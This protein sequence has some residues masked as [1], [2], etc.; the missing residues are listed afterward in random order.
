MQYTQRKLQRSV[1]EIRKYVIGRL[2]ASASGGCALAGLA[3]RSIGS[4]TIST[5]LAAG[6]PDSVPALL[7]LEH[8]IGDLHV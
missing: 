7:L 1:T 6:R 5:T 4:E 3:I 8:R 2:N